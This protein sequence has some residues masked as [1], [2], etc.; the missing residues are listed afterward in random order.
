MNAQG[1][2]PRRIG[3]DLL[4]PGAAIL[5]SLLLVWLATRS[6]AALL[7]FV[8]GLAALGGIAWALTR[9]TAA[10]AEPEYALPDWSVT[11]A[12]IEQDNVAVAVTDRAGDRK[13]VV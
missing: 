4:V 11:V 1:S 6:F 8:A 2:A 9:S 5:A 3:G 10:P 13:S 12:A 7:A